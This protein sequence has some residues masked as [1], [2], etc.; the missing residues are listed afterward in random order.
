MNACCGSIGAVMMMS[1]IEDKIALI[2]V[3]YEMACTDAET[4]FV[5]SRQQK[6]DI[7]LAM[8]ILGV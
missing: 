6:S 5:S 8:A 4:P 7:C 2:E 1:C 3:D